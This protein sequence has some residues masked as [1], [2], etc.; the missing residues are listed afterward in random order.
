MVR[1][2]MD[3]GNVGDKTIYVFPLTITKV[4]IAGILCGKLNK[5]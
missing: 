5:I 2:N 4:I 3:S 1:K